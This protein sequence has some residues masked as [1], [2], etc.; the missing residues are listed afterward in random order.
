[1]YSNSSGEKSMSSKFL[2]AV[3]LVSFVSLTVKADRSLISKGPYFVIQSNGIVIHKIH[4]NGQ[5]EIF[6]YDLGSGKAAVQRID[7]EIDSQRIE[8]GS[9]HTTN[10]AAIVDWV[11]M[12]DGYTYGAI[13][14]PP[15]EELF[16]IETSKFKNKGSQIEYKAFKNLCDT[17]VFIP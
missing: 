8:K 3:F 1:M 14:G 11:S 6:R 13:F 5:T 16:V 9:F 17:V 4:N 15:G 7:N 10:N 2:V 12:K